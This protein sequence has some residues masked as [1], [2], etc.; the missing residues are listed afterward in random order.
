MK[1]DL[2]EIELQRREADLSIELARTSGT[3]FDEA[4]NVE[5][6]LAQV[7]RDRAEIQLHR[8]KDEIDAEISDI[9]DTDEEQ[10]NGDANG[11]EEPVPKRVKM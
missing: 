5:A 1:I 4:A 8:R 11:T 10:M 2:D 9:E 3:L 7:R 6:R